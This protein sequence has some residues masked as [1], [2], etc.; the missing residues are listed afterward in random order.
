[1]SD[2]DMNV[3]VAIKSIISFVLLLFTIVVV[4]SDVLHRV[5][6]NCPSLLAP[7]LKALLQS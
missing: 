1:M 3:T 2:E 7:I 4:G 5:G 6:V